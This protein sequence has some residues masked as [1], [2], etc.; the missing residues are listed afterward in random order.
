MQNKRGVLCCA[1]SLSWGKNIPSLFCYLDHLHR[2]RVTHSVCVWKKM[3]R[4]S[5]KIFPPLSRWR[6]S[7]SNVLF[8]IKVK[9]F[10][11]AFFTAKFMCSS[12]LTLTPKAGIETILLL[13]ICLYLH[14]ESEPNPHIHWLN[15]V[16]TQFKVSF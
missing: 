8:S 11:S 10:Q 16:M 12:F 2:Q 13:Y 6:D 4:K 15:S 3:S 1:C 9:T 7:V 5:K 14:L